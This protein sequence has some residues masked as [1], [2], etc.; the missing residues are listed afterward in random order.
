MAVTVQVSSGGEL[1]R[2]MS[3]IAVRYRRQHP[4]PEPERASGSFPIASH[5]DG[6]PAIKTLAWFPSVGCW[7]SHSGGCTFCDFGEMADPGSLDEVVASFEAHLADLDPGLRNLHLAPGGSFFSDRELD[8][9]TRRAIIQTTARFPFLRSLGFE[10]RPDELTVPKLLDAVRDSPA[11]VRDIYVGFGLEARSDLIREVT[12]NKGYG[13]DAVLSAKHVIDE[14]NGQQSRVRVHFE[15][16]VMIKPMFLT[17]SEGIDEALRTVDWSYENGAS[18]VVL[19]LNTVKEA[20]LQHVLSEADAPSPLRFSPPFLR[21]GVEALRRLPADQRVRTVLLGVQSGVL[22]QGMPQG[23]ELCRPVL[24]GALMAH[25]F[26]REA[27]VLESAAASHCPC[28]ASWEEALAVVPATS[29][30]DRISDGLD[31]LETMVPSGHETVG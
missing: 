26:T 15:T 13:I 10:T 2:R 16:Y 17:E 8:D 5:I 24:L 1:S 22:A 18:T 19:F 31:L 4:L 28:K 11:S 21:S 29:I 30:R 7:W 27:S 14:V 12:V 23:C 25:N 9:E 6:Q 20:T 3:R